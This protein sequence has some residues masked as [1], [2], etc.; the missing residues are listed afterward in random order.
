MK[1]TKPPPPCRKITR[2]TIKAQWRKASAL[3]SQQQRR[4]FMQAIHQGKT[5]GEASAAAGMSFEAAIGTLNRNIVKHE[6]LR[7]VEDVG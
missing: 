5:I 7:P 4:Q 6:Y 1:K 3:C 2:A